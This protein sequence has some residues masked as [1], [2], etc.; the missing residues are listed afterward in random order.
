VTAIADD[1]LRLTFSDTNGGWQRELR[2]GPSERSFV[3]KSTFDEPFVAGRTYVFTLEPTSPR[4]RIVN[5]VHPAIA[6]PMAAKVTRNGTAFPVVFA[7]GYVD[8]GDGLVQVG[9]DKG[10]DLGVGARTRSRCW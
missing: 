6:M 3:A 9:L 4:G 2:L 1:A 7:L 5:G 8:D 10:L